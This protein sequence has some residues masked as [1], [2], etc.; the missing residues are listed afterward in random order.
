MMRS[1]STLALLFT[2]ALAPAQ[3][4]NIDPAS[5]RAEFAIR[6]SS[7]AGTAKGGRR[8]MLLVDPTGRG[9]LRVSNKFPY[10]A[11]QQWNYADVGVNIECRV[12]DVK[13]KLAVGAE[14]DV[15]SSLDPAKNPT[16]PAAPPTISNV[17]L[18]INAVLA[19]GKPAL[20]GSFNDPLA[21]RMFEVQVT[22]TR[23][24]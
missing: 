22:V 15:S 6:D 24:D 19:P 16:G 8:Y 2:A 12:R 7:D 21:N 10:P 14:V 9:S 18:S 13:G 5:Y 3:E 17:R 4:N 11:G 20:V 1:L 23:V